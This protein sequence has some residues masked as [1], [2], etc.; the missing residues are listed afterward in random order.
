MSGQ[1]PCCFVWVDCVCQ[2]SRSVQPWRVGYVGVSRS[3]VQ[4]WQPRGLVPSWGPACNVRCPI[5][6]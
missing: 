6:R 5:T 4:A 1:V 2:G 3:R